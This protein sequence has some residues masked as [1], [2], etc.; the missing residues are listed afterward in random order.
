LREKLIKIAYAMHDF[1][2]LRT[3]A[4]KKPNP[5]AN[6]LESDREHCSLLSA[7]CWLGGGYLHGACIDRPQL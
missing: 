2:L 5:E 3:S 7:A 4:G 1:P 6:E